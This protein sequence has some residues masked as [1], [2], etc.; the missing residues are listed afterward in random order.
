MGSYE[1]VR[2]TSIDAE[3]GRVHELINDFHQWRTSR[4]AWPG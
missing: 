2:S 3:P 1:V 4:R